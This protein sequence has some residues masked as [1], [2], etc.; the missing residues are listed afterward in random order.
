MFFKRA[1]VKQKETAGLS[2]A[3]HFGEMT[4]GEGGASR[5]AVAE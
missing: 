3:L 4:K 1:E 5:R 2:T